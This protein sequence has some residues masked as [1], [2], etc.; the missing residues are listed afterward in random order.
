[1]HGQETVNDALIASY[2]QFKMEVSIYYI[3]SKG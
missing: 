2:T 3:N 1:M